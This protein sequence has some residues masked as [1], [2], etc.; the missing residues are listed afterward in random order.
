[1]TELRPRVVG[2]AVAHD[3]LDLASALREALH[4]AVGAVSAEVDVEQ[5]E[6]AV[7]RLAMMT[8]HHG[9]EAV[10]IVGAHARVEERVR[11]V[12]VAAVPGALLRAVRV[13]REEDARA[14]VRDVGVFPVEEHHAAVGHHVRTPVVVLVERKAANG[15]VRLATIDASHPA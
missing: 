11:P 14:V 8:C 4:H 10:W 6:L 2:E 3:W 7:S 9:G 1:M 12:A 13:H 5:D 15:A